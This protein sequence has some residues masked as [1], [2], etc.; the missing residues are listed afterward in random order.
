MALLRFSPRANVVAY[1]NDRY[2]KSVGYRDAISWLKGLPLHYAISH[3]PV[4]DEKQIR[5]FWQ[6][7]D[8]DLSKEPHIIY[9][10][11]ESEHISITIDTIAKA[12]KLEGGTPILLD[13]NLVFEG[14]K[15]MGYEKKEFTTRREIKKTY[16]SNE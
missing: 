9:A 6:S 16:L 10:M 14:F 11:V 13:E 3:L 15:S 5:A 7:A 4:I 12:L 8:Y 1:L 2:P